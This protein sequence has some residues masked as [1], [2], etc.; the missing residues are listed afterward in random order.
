MDVPAIACYCPLLLSLLLEQR[1]VG[2]SHLK[3]KVLAS[4]G[5]EG[6]DAIAFNHLPEN[7]PAGNSV[8]LLYRLDINRWRG[9]ETCQLMVDRIVKE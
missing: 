4:G 5:D 9:S 2:G 3:M 8:R 6:L 7:L 1:V